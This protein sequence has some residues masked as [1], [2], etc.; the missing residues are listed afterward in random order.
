MPVTTLVKSIFVDH[1]S[2]VLAKPKDKFAIEYFGANSAVAKLIAAKGFTDP[3][4]ADY[5]QIAASQQFISLVKESSLIGQIEALGKHKSM[6]LN[7]KLSSF[8]LSPCKVVPQAIPTE[9]LTESSE[10]GFELDFKKIGGYAIFPDKYFTSAF[11]SKVEPLINEALVNSY[12]VGE[13]DDFITSITT[14][15][16]TVLATGSTMPA[17]LTDIQ[18]SLES[19]DDPQDVVI[20][21][22]PKVALKIANELELD[23]LGVNGGNIRGIPVIT[24]KAV[25]TT[26]KII[27]DVTKL[28]LAADPSVE[29]R[30]T[31]EATVKDMTGSNVYLFQENKIALQ[32]MGINGY[33]FMTGN[34]ATVIEG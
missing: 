10:L 17:L 3:T 6:P 4:Q 9:I 29:I 32:I 20:L 2:Q 18:S 26:K 1:N 27:F 13:N 30:K 31:G 23:S 21:L 34:V 24:N 25:P 11:F 16:T 12:V 15:A 19:I 5:A 8:D 22:N 33:E 28:V 7:T 14:G